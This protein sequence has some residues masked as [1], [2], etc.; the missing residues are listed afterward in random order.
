VGIKTTATPGRVFLVHV[1][2]IL[3]LSRDPTATDCCWSR[4]HHTDHT[5]TMS[6]GEKQ[7]IRC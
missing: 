2:N 1:C 3:P 7:R 6:C 4:P 5:I